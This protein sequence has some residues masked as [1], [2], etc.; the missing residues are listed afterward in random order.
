MAKGAALGAP[1]REFQP[2]KLTIQTQTAALLEIRS[3]K[4]KTKAKGNIGEGV[5]VQR[6]GL[7][8][9]GCDALFAE[10]VNGLWKRIKNPR[11]QNSEVQSS[12]STW[13]R[14]PASIPRVDVLLS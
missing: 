1:S 12:D 4:R 10:I 5:E 9:K 11:I 14:R 7:S 8:A 2:R 13:Q 3:R 6:M